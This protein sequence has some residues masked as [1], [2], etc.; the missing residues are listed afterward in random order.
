MKR[1]IIPV[2]AALCA[3]LLLLSACALIRQ[4]T[5]QPPEGAYKVYFATAGKAAAAQSVDFEYRQVPEGEDVVAALTAAILGG[6]TA[7]NTALASPMPSGVV[8]RS[9]VLGED[10]QLHLNLSEQYG[11]LS[12]VDLTMANACFVLTLCQAAGVKSVYITVEG[13]SSPF[14]TLKTLSESDFLITGGETKPVSATVRLFFPRADGMGLGVEEQ[15]L[16]VGE[17]DTLTASVVSALLAGPQSQALWG[18][19]PAGAALR[20]TRVEDGVC[21]VSLSESFFTAAG[22]D[23]N[24]AHLALYA[25]VNTLCALQDA[26]IERVELRMEGSAVMAYGSIP[27]N[28]P[29]APDNSLAVAAGNMG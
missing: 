6:P 7:E 22:E 4:Q 16:T 10:G 11:G 20:G 18:I 17:S 19:A 14:Q 3:A 8:L 21:T 28:S 12:G 26:R 13:E 2:L 25:L 29:L 9:A 5:P 24:A 27:I 23:E 1:R 15:V